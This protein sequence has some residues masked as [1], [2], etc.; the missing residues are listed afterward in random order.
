MSTVERAMNAQIK[1][2]NKV[3]ARFAMFVGKDELAAGRF[4][5]KD[6]ASGDQ[7]ELDEAG[8]IARVKDGHGDA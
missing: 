3:G 8:L 7:E 5:L 1:R 6:L 2:A 4:G